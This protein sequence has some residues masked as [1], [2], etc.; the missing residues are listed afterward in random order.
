[1]KKIFNLV[2]ALIFLLVTFSTF[3]GYVLYNAEVVIYRELYTLPVENPKIILF[4]IYSFSVVV[5]LIFI[6]IT[7]DYKQRKK[8]LRREDLMKNVSTGFDTCNDATCYQ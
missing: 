4:S 7:E 8:I 5:F 1:M 2:N 3:L 6:A